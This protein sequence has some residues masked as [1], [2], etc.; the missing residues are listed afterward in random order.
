MTR[1]IGQQY[2][3]GSLPAYRGVVMQRGYGLG[4]IF[5]GFARAL[6][7]KIKQGL[8]HVGKRALKT[9]IEV[10]GDVVQG[11]NIKTALKRRS[12]S[13]F[14]EMIQ[15]NKRQKSSYN[16]AKLSRTQPSMKRGRTKK[17]KRSSTTLGVL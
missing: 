14:V 9:G 16:K 1:I 4:G 7:P 12:K 15:P 8:K 17:K 6:A 3:Y 13:N 2:G 10:L 5:R 11:E